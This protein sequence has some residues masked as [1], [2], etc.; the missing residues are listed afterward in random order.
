[1][2]LEGAV[3][4]GFCKELAAIENDDERDAEFRR[5]VDAMHARGKATSMASVLEIDGVIDPADTRHWIAQGLR[6]VQPA[7]PRVGKKRQDV[8][9]W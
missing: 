4:L 5:R 7:T 2:G 8:A 1:M 9:T 3:R 6:M